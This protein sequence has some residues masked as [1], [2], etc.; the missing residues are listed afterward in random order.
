LPE[1]KLKVYSRILALLEEK[2]EGLTWGVLMEKLGCG[3]STLSRNI[4]KAISEG[5]VIEVNLEGKTVYVLSS[6]Q[7]QE[8]LRQKIAQA[9]DSVS[10]YPLGTVATSYGTLYGEEYTVEAS[11]MEAVNFI[12][13][14]QQGRKIWKIFSDYREKER[15]QLLKVFAAVVLEGLHYCLREG[16]VSTESKFENQLR[17]NPKTIFQIISRNFDLFLECGLSKVAPSFDKKSHLRILVLE[18]KKTLLEEYFP[19]KNLERHMA[20]M[21]FSSQDQRLLSDFL[22]KFGETR[23]MLVVPFGFP[24]LEESGLESAAENFQRFN[25]WMQRLKEG[26]FDLKHASFLFVD[27]TRNLKRIIKVLK[28]KSDFRKPTDINLAMK[29]LRRLLAPSHLSPTKAELRLAVDL[30]EPWDLL[31]LYERH[32]RGKQP[33]FYSEIYSLVKN[34]RDEA[35]RRKLLTI[36][37]KE[38]NIRKIVM[39]RTGFMVYYKG[40]DRPELLGPHDHTKEDRHDKT[41]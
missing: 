15:L 11:I 9:L 23:F 27:G 18:L 5:G 19:A 16:I 29:G 39:T 7:V 24:K 37:T 35:I 1:R 30:R 8:L 33:N 28:S 31:F 10:L 25:L 41:A 38:E 14:Q 20:G 21:E 12:L 40:Q 2:K 6:S 3:R 36:P 32:P 34:R 4:N 17:V 26:P 13:Q 22:D